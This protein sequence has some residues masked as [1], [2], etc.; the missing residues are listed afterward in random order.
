MRRGFSAAGDADAGSRGTPG[1]LS[2]WFRPLYAPPTVNE[3]PP[4]RWTALLNPAAGRGRARARLGKVHDALR[5]SGID[6]AIHDTT[7]AA[8]LRA[9]AVAAFDDGRGVIACG[10]DGTVSAVAGCAAVRDGVMGIVPTG[11]GNDLARHL[12]VPRHDPA[13]AVAVVADG[14][15][16]R[17]DLGRAE[18][19]DGAR[20]WFTTV[21]NAG[22]D[23]EANRWANTRARL[24]GTP[25]YVAAV[26]RTLG[27]YRP[28]PVRIAVDGSVAEIEAWLVAVANTRSYAGGMLIAPTASMHDGLLDVCV[29]G[30]VSRVEFLRTFPGVFRGTH[31]RHAQITSRRGREVVIDALGGRASEL[32]ASGER[33]GPLPATVTAQPAALRVM[34]ERA[35]PPGARALTG[36]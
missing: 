22:F 31:V 8:H 6:V 17:V 34:V 30:P 26:L 25:L 16:A 2:R 18:T 9:L 12:G 10:G 5:G 21:A 20:A 4:E 7:S 3:T 27:T 24:T 1:K 28:E 23:A 33:V 29:V 36:P 35:V 11:S 15:V 14:A 32:W 19:A 13:A